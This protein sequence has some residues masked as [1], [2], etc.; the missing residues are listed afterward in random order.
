MTGDIA[1]RDLRRRALELAVASGGELREHARRVARLALVVA[2]GLGL[3]EDARLEVELVALLHD[4]GK[5]AL[6]MR[7]LAKAAPLDED[8]WALMRIHTLEG[9]RMVLE[10]GMGERLGA[11]VRATHERWDGD[12]YPDGLR[13]HEIP[14]SARIV[15]GADAYDAMTCARPYRA[16]LPAAF[17][18]GELR[19]GAGTQ[20][21]PFIA[22]RLAATVERL[23]CR[24]R[25]TSRDRDPRAALGR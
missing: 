25:R 7:V 18:L 11:L 4:V 14:L 5:A 6:P 8:E 20:F 13:A 3:D 1:G 19:R 16:A 15:F 9:E 17:A 21:D 23:E 22:Q 2:E 24:L 10:A 12:G